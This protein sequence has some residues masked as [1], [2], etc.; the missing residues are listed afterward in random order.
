MNYIN[1]HTPSFENSYNCPDFKNY[2][3]S[4][5]PSKKTKESPSVEEFLYPIDEMSDFHDPYSEISLFLSE[6]IKA[7]VKES[8]HAKKWTLKLQETLLEKITPEFKKRF[9][10]YRL[11]VLTLK[12]AW[13]K[14]IYYLQQIENHQ[15]ALTQEGKLNVDFLIQ[16]H[17]KQF[18]RLHFMKFNTAY[19]QTHH[20]AGKICEFCATIDGFKPD[21]D[22][23][24]KKIWDQLKH[25]LTDLETHQ[26]NPYKILDQTDFV[27]RKLSMEILSK[28]PMISSK[29][30][31]ASI[32]DSLYF[33]D[34]ISLIPQDTLSSCLYTLLAEK[35]WLKSVSGLRITTS[36]LNTLLCFISK[37]LDS[38]KKNHP[39]DT[40]KE[41]V[42]KVA[43][44]YEIITQLPKQLT[45]G[46]IE[47][48]VDD[49]FTNQKNPILL[50]TSSLIALTSSEMPFFQKNGLDLN[51]KKIKEDIF[52][53]YQ[54]WI[55]LPKIDL[56]QLG[57][58]EIAAWKFIAAHK[59]QSK[60][61]TP[62]LQEKIS[63]EME[64]IVIDYP[65]LCFQALAEK[66]E[67]SFHI[68]KSAAANGMTKEIED[69][70]H[71]AAL[72]NEMICTN[73]EIDNQISLV[74]IIL[75]QLRQNPKR[76]QREVIE[77]ATKQF[78]NENPYI[79]VKATHISQRA[80]I[81]FKYLWYSVLK[82]EDESNF[83]RFILGHNELIEKET[84]PSKI[85]HSLKELCQRK[86]PLMSLE[87][88]F[89]RRLFCFTHKQKCS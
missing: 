15:E 24:T 39:Q 22:F 77:H 13:E 66:V 82:K 53:L 14:V 49:Y 55:L 20:L 65:Y 32:L 42:R 50:P 12:K 81:Y 18:S 56:N 79:Q 68:A 59:E 72:Q 1:N 9:P 54:E 37:H 87:E 7:E 34:E 78:L 70:V 89:T 43:Y 2:I 64:K 75:K 26:K 6:K 88:D 3:G 17:L 30:L 46:E 52:N 63:N 71:I 73:I 27:I 38:G 85:T 86:T 69:K 23:L 21:W 44:L 61:L 47:L 4:S 67:R 80:W 58:I 41:N 28:K 10:R 51:E 84:C 29:E 8:A 36:E 60:S 31:E 19:Q 76:N 16:E 33:Y 40:D 45:K 25:I 35:C 74:G 11:G 48:A 5:V 57:F 83:E 62:V